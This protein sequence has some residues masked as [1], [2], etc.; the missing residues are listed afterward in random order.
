MEMNYQEKTLRKAWTIMRKAAVTER[1][2]VGKA[3]PYDQ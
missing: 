3:L 2:Q 1:I